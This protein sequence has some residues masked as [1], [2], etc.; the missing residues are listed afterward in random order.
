MPLKGQHQS[1]EAKQKLREARAKQVHPSLAKRGITTADV[2]DASAKGLR[3]CSKDC[4]AFVPVDQF[5][6]NS[7][8]ACRDCTAK[9]VQR[10]RDRWSPEQRA[11]SVSA[12]KQWRR[13]HPNYDRAYRLGYTYGVSVEWYEQKLAEQDSKCAICETSGYGSKSVKV[14]C[15]DHDHET[16]KVRG[17]LC[18][19]CN[20]ALEHWREMPE[21]FRAYV[22]KHK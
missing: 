8:K 3:W 4:K 16:G 5:A 14:F 6:G 2:A 18:V 15:V 17:L 20:V 12:I 7:S 10:T 9:S 21:S 1:E 19:G 22:E 13:D 11:L